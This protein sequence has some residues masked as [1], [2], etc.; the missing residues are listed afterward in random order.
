MLHL[1]KR[2]FQLKM[3]HSLIRMQENDYN[4]EKELNPI[5]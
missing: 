5:Q 3:L 2:I 4:V 1:W